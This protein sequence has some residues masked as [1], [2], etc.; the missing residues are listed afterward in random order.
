[1]QV[2]SQRVCLD[3]IRKCTTGADHLEIWLD[4]DVRSNCILIPGYGHPLRKDRICGK[5]GGGGAIYVKDHIVGKRRY[6]FEYLLNCLTVWSFFGPS[7]ILIVSS[8]FVEFVTVL[9]ITQL[10]TKGYSMSYHS[11]VLTKS[12][13]AVIVFQLLL[14]LVT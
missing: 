11:S 13:R 4:S 5:R 1:M 8:F 2:S 12:N 9:L 7:A 10:K 14:F 6:D 3:S